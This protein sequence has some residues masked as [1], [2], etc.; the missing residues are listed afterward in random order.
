MDIEIRRLVKSLIRSLNK[1]INYVCNSYDPYLKFE[2]CN[3]LRSIYLHLYI[4]NLFGVQFLDTE[5]IL[6]ETP[7]LLRQIKEGLNIRSSDMY[8]DLEYWSDLVM[9]TLDELFRTIYA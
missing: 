8:R 5:W 4:A 9:K 3:E 6:R 1:I 7:K 2:P